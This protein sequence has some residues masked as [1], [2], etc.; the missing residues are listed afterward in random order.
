VKCPRHPRSKKSRASFFKRLLSHPSLPLLLG[1]MMGTR[2][3]S[4]KLLVDVLR[5]LGSGLVDHLDLGC[6]ASGVQSR[7]LRLTTGVLR[8]RL[9][10]RKKHQSKKKYRP[11]HRHELFPNRLSLPK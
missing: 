7:P 11:R 5:L 3:P 8:R 6:L 1:V 10:R 2:H 9:S 4:R